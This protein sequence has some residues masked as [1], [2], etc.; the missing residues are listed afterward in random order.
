MFWPSILS[1]LFCVLFCFTQVS[2]FVPLQDYLLAYLRTFGIKFVYRPTWILRIVPLGYTIAK[3]AHHAR[4][5]SWRYIS[6]GRR[7]WSPNFLRWPLLCE[8]GPISV[9][10]KYLLCQCKP[11][12]IKCSPTNILTFPLTTQSWP[13]LFRNVR[14]TVRTT[15]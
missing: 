13:A 8:L 6:K 5:H 7:M 4:W 12:K 3:K 10:Q 1:D 15:T 14:C 11:R 2:K 9:Q